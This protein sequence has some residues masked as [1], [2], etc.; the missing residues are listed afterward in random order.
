MKLSRDVPWVKLY[1]KCSKNLIP[2]ITLVAIATKKGK[3]A[4]F[5]KVLFSETRCHTALIFGV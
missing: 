1:K 4:K 2:S 3:N 5:L